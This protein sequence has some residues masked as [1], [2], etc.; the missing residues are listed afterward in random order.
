MGIMK[1]FFFTAILLF[2]ILCINAQDLRSYQVGTN[3][4]LRDVASRFQV[5]IATLKQ[6]NPNIRGNT[7]SGLLLVVPNAPNFQLNPKVK[8]IA[9]E[10]SPKETLYSISKSYNLKIKD[11]KAYNPFLKEREL[12]YNDVLRIPTYELKDKDLDINQ[13]VKNSEFSSLMHLVLPKETKYG[14]SSKYGLTVAQLEDLNPGIDEKEIQPGQFLKIKRPVNTSDK[15]IP[16]NQNYAFLKVDSKNSLESISESYDVTEEELLE[17]NPS[18]KFEGISE[19]LVLKIP[20]FEDVKASK[21]EAFSFEGKLKYFDTKQVAVMLPLNLQKTEIDS[22]TSKSLLKN[23]ALLRISLDFYEG[24]QMAIDS[25]RTRGITVNL[26]VY[27]TRND[28]VHVNS[29]LNDNFKTYEAIV[30]PLLDPSLRV[31]ANYTERFNV[32]VISPLVNPN[33][34][35]DNLFN[36]LPKDEEMQEMIITYL[37]SIHQDENLTILSDSISKPIQS[38]FAHTFPEINIVSQA[39]EGYIKRSDLRPHLD[40]LGTNWFILETQNLG[41]AE[42]T[43]SFLKSYQRD[44]FDIRLFTSKRNSFYDDDISNYYLSDL[45]FTFP[46]ISKTQLITDKNNYHNGYLNTHGVYPNRYVIRGYDVMMDLLLRLSYAKSLQASTEIEGY[47]EYAE[48]K[49]NYTKKEFTKGYEN[50]AIYLL[51]YE[52]GLQIKALDVKEFLLVDDY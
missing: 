40:S 22:I 11:L 37:Q 36:T 18:L 29:L 35:F 15:Q 24:I 20:Q 17:S 5:D 10:V 52:K 45:K 1:K 9:Y 12:N 14:I 19:G 8:L 27:D 7:I 46:S 51:Q 41:I 3:E 50:E 33:F 48:N 47:T 4:N 2:T 16:K 28:P 25:A 13:S 44:G 23:S 6:L 38:K 21:Y 42:S 49:F 30:G 34:E 26:D 32:P 43:V 39:E 31:V